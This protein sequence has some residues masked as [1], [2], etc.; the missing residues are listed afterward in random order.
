MELI[1]AVV[2]S[3]IALVSMEFS[4][5]TYKNTASY[6]RKQATLEAYNRLQEEVFDSI[7][8]YTPKDIADICMNSKSTEYKVLSGYLA[9]LEHFCIGVNEKIYDKDVFYK[10]AHGYF[11]GHI[12]Y[13]RIEPILMS[14][15]NPE[16][17]YSNIYHVLEWMNKK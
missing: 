17:Y 7:N 5:I 1:I 16:Q 13:R 2:S 11:D 10:M 14:K 15:N 4:I 12:L 9:R 6:D 3:L 8:S